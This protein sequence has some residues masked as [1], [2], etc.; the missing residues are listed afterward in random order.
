MLIYPLTIINLVFT[1]ISWELF[2]LWGIDIET[3]QTISNPV[4]L[5]S[6]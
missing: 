2:E 6:A 5:R 1:K 3:S 4:R